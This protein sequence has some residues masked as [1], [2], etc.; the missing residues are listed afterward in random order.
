VY[1]ATGLDLTQVK[2]KHG[3]GWDILEKR[4]YN[5]Q[6]EPLTITDAAGQT[7]TFTYNAAGQLLTRTNAKGETTTYAYNAS[8]Y[9]QN[10]TGALA[11][12]T[13][14]L[15]YDGYGRIGSITDSEGYAVTL[16]YDAAGRVTRT[17]YPDRHLRTDDVRSAG[18]E[19]VAR[20]AGPANGLHVQRQSGA[21]GRAASAGPADVVRS[22]P[23]R[24]A[25]QQK[26]RRKVNGSNH[27]R[28]GS[29]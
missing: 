6:H 26:L 10:I 3:T 19:G 22:V 16:Q 12:A 11:G 18:S 17:T 25:E 7:T 29:V 8:G 4:T 1:D 15:G 21:G 14:T 24:R 5:S 2:Q 23:V 13:T 28:N 20:P 9:L 27:R